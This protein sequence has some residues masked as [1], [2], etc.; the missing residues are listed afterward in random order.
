MCHLQML[1]ANNSVSFSVLVSTLN[2]GRTFWNMVPYIHTNVTILCDKEE[3]KNGDSKRNNTIILRAATSSG[4]LQCVCESTG[5]STRVVYLFL[6]TQQ[7][8]HSFQL[9]KE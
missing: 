8:K 5:C 1:K 7:N 2:G 3:G 4:Q 9:T 6:I